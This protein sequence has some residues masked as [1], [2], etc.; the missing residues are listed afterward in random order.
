MTSADVRLIRIVSSIRM[1]VSACHR[2]QSSGSA[3]TAKARH[4]APDYY[5]VNSSESGRRLRWSV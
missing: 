2:D 5:G 3:V 4:R 1:T